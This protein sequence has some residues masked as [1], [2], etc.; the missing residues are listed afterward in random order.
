MA[1]RPQYR[2]NPAEV[3]RVI[4]APVRV[5]LDPASRTAAVFETGRGAVEAPCYDCAG[6]R[7]WGA[8]SM[9]LSEFSALLR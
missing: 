2:P 5:F 4:E 9:I 7:V 6:D 1:S 8:T 3:K